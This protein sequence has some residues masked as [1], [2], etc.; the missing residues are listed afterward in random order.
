MSVADYTMEHAI[1]ALEPLAPNGATWP[2][3]DITGEAK[4]GAISCGHGQRN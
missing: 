3:A 2:K 1:G 4:S